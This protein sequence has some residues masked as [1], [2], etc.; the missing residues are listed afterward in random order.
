M[1]DA[2]RA[3]PGPGA[4]LPVPVVAVVGRP[5]VGKSTLVNRILG[6]RQAVVEDVP[7]VTRDRVTY[8]A[9]WRG[10]AFTLVDT[11]GWEPSTEK[12]EALAGRVAAQARVA[13]DAADAVLFVVDAVVGVTDAD[14][15]VAAVLRRSRKPVVLAANKVDDAPGE[16]EVHSLWALG[17]GEPLAVSALHGRGSGELLDAVLNALPDAPAERYDAEGGPRRVALI[18]RPNVGKSSLLNKLAGKERVLV[19]PVAG[20]TRDPVDELIELG[21]KTWR[22]VDTAGIRR[23][24][25][26]TQGADYFAALRTE[27]A[28]ERAEVAVVLVDASEPLAEQDLR[29]ISMVIDAGRALVIAYNKWDLVDADRREFLDKEIDRQLHNARWAPRVNISAKT[30]WHVDRL[31]PALELALDGW[32]ARVQTGRLNAWLSAL[33]AA[34]PPPL[35][36]GKQPKIMFATQAGIRPPHFV[37]FTSGF[38]QAGYRRFIERK[39]REEFGFAGTPV[40]VTMR[41][42]EKRTGP[43][44]RAARGP[45]R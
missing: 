40:H 37:L 24:V 35:R 18:G 38:L 41:L 8:D 16:P 26:N 5:N 45:G 19:D 21:G 25:H 3:E 34:T 11:G 30:G 15:V 28:L 32:E 23:R 6:S 44:G 39:L 7:G 22:F 1:A 33:I 14:A 2:D 17:L 13:V 9:T 12:T 4:D 29:I 10:R 43:S 42:R 20:T 27:R 31:V 36:G